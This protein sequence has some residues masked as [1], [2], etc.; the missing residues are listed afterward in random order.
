MKIKD[1]REK[2]RDYKISYIPKKDYLIGIT[3]K[4]K[5]RRQDLYDEVYIARKDSKY[6]LLYPVTNNFTRCFKNRKN[7]IDWFKNGGR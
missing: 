7:T 3:E 4:F 6:Y 2:Y 1:V 5:K